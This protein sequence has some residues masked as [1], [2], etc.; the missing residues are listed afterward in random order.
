MEENELLKL[1]FELKD[2]VLAEKK[3]IFL[4]NFESK[5]LN[6]VVMDKRII[7]DKIEKLLKKY[8]KIDD[9]LN[10]KLKNII[11]EL[12]KLEEE[13]RNIYTNK[14]KEIQNKMGNLHT[15]RKLKNTYIHSNSGSRVLDQKK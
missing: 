13:N 15:E 2:K 11:K 7:R 5:D 8:P 3:I 14:M 9:K 4:E 12:L 10:S 6:K 1:Y